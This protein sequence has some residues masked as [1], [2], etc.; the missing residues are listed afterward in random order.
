MA[1]YK[2]IAKSS[3]IVG[4]VQIF[5]MVF[6]LVR[7]KAVSFL[8]GSAAFGLYSIYQT[9]V[10]MVSA[11]AILGLN[12]SSV[13]EIARCNSDKEKVGKIYYTVNRLTLI[14]SGIV[15][16]ITIIFSKSIS[17]YLFNEEGHEYGISIVA[18]IMLFSVFAKE[19]YAILNGIRNL[20][21]LAISQIVSSA[22]GSLGTIIAVFL[23]GIKS[24]PSVLGIIYV[25]MSVI[26]FYYVRKNNIHKVKPH[27]DEFRS[28]SKNLLNIGIGVTIAGIVSTVMTIMSKS[29]LTEH[30]SMSAVGLYQASWTISN[31]YTGIV[32]NAMGVDFMPRISKVIDNSKEASE[33]INQQTIFGVVVSSIAITG[34]LLFSKE[35]LYILYSPEFTQ[36]DIIIRWQ[37]LGVF[38]RVLAFPFGF[39]I[40][41]KGK[42]KAYATAQFIFWTSD[43]LLLILCSHIWGF[44]GLGVN[45][46]IA[47]CGYLSLTFIIT[48][49][50]CNFTYSREL[51]KVLLVLFS[52]IGIAWGIS[53]L[54]I[55][56]ICIR[57]I[58]NILFLI[59]HFV[60]I[61]HYMVKKMDMN[62]W[63]TIKQRMKKKKH[64]KK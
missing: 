33:L 43:F 53:S 56:N 41:A 1:T 7:N 61:N 57:Y 36:A 10:E 58:T 13:R 2:S 48:K 24:I 23:W 25:T 31:L 29:Y 44:I 47:Y 6:S 27:H 52:F 11:F 63:E 8:L 28:I 20:R 34:I 19:G 64:D 22:L 17:I 38:L 3:G 18:V 30:F 55:E 42:A 59:V 39:T 50:I 15:F 5:Q 46:L 62:L 49:K 40:L 12:N 4:F 37:V 26:T 54:D 14:S 60:F 45:Y 16:L 32:L 9:F 35:I 21:D 51:I